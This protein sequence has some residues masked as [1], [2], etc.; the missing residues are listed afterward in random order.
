MVIDSVFILHLVFIIFF[1][2]IPFWDIKYLKYGAYFPLILA[3]VWIIFNGCPLTSIQAGLND[4]YFSQ[5]LLKPF[6]P[7]I[8]KEQTTRVTYYILLVVAYASLYR[9]YKIRRQ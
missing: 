2:S 6:F 5:I 1:L 7:N 9:L 3:T 4:E 8:T